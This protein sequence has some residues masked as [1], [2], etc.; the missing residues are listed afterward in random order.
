MSGRAR[1]FAVAAFAGTVLAA[2]GLG[3]FPFADVALGGFGLGPAPAQAQEFGAYD[4]NLREPSSTAV[5]SL[6][7]LDSLRTYAYRFRLLRLADSLA[8]YP[9]AD[10]CPSIPWSPFTLPPRPAEPC[11]GLIF[12]DGREARWDEL[13]PW[14]AERY[15]P[16][17]ECC[18]ALGLTL[19]WDP[20]FFRGILR[21]DTL[22]IRFVVGGETLHGAGKALQMRG[23]VAY[24][25]N[26][27]LFPAS[28]VPLL[29][30][31]F[32][33]G[34]F[35]F[36]DA[37][38]V[39]TQIPQGPL[40]GDLRAQEAG[41]RTYL[42][43][44]LPREPQARLTTSG[45]SRLTVE[46]PGAFLDPRRPPFAQYRQGTC[47]LS[48]END[49]TGSRYAWAID[50]AVVAWKE[51]WLSDK[52]EYQVI[53]STRR[54]DV[55]TLS[56][57]RAWPVPYSPSE[58]SPRAV[59]IVTPAEDLYAGGNAE[60]LGRAA[61][62]HLDFLAQRIG[63]AL[64]E[65]GITALRLR[66]QAN[67]DS[68][69]VPRANAQGAIACLDLR[70][71]LAGDSLLAGIRVVT[72]ISDP[73]GKS[74]RPPE[75]GALERDPG[76]R[77]DSGWRSSRSRSSLRPWG[78]TAGRHEQ[79]SRNFARLL[80]LYLQ[81]AL[82]ADER[83]PGVPVAQQ[84]WPLSS[85]EGLDM[86]GA[87][88]YIGRAGPMALYPADEDWRAIDRIAEALAMAVDGYAL[89]EGWPR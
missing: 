58:T 28:G 83:M 3:A 20:A 24:A 5:D 59:A 27:L 39:V 54:E 72:C 8:L 75:S 12:A 23:P 81:T 17:E 46:L 78:E 55:S 88:L 51:Q 26:R 84:R 86:P 10:E 35:V 14:G 79:A 25:Q 49:G 30:E 74:I 53:L 37:K 6:A 38:S 87:I 64:E 16:M 31:H 1:H 65:R 61:A 9:E 82:S 50:P 42:R 11:I 18:A 80:V 47:L 29:V 22:A 33:S 13:V 7:L 36:D 77:V 66:D 85:F 69:W 43:W 60:N 71:A 52:R 21:A 48:M 34:K 67:E 45:S 63:E 68:A 15:W 2:A 70:P 19:E 76:D 4:R 41:G 44:A 89:Q 32:L 56:A 57:Y 62:Q 73:F 40:V